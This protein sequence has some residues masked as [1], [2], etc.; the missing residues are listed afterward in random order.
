MNSY[1]LTG[2][3]SPSAVLSKRITIGIHEKKVVKNG[4]VAH[5][6]HLHAVVGLGMRNPFD[7]FF[8][9]SGINRF[10]ASAKQVLSRVPG[11]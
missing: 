8:F 1:R 7:D 10:D 3:V 11:G 5:R 9:L 6:A 2:S 4:F